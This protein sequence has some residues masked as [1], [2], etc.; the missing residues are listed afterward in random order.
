MALTDKEKMVEI[1]KILDAKKA[2]KIGAIFVEEKT[3][4]A[5]YFVIC[6]AGSLTQLRALADELEE[7]MGE[8]GEPPV[9]I[10]GKNESGWTLVDFGGVIVHI[11]TAEMRE[12]YD[13]ERL[14]TDA[15]KVDLTDLLTKD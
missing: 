12:F 5:S 14:W 10:E 9:K 6:T 7:K 13:L 11:F 8:K 15:P 3:I 4:I 1:V 2:G